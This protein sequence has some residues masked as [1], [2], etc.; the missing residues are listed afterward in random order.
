MVVADEP[1][2]YTGQS[3]GTGVGLSRDSPS[4]D[5][6]STSRYFT[7]NLQDTSHKAMQ[8]APSNYK[9]GRKVLDAITS[10][11][12]Y[13]LGFRGAPTSTSKD[14]SPLTCQPPLLWLLQFSTRE[15]W[16]CDS[17]LL[18]LLKESSPSTDV[19]Y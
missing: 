14:A 8:E 7:K 3:D 12:A 18:L 13:D 2:E 9:T 15:R 4:I 11:N 1:A 5:P 6:H 19:F 16:R 10:R 17:Y